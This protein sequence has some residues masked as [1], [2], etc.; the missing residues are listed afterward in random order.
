MEAYMPNTRFK[1]LAAA[2]PSLA[3]C[4]ISTSALAG[5]PAMSEAPT[6]ADYFNGADSSG[7]AALDSAEFR[8]FVDT[9]ADGG[10]AEAIG[11]RESGDYDAAFVKVDADADGIVTYLEASAH[12]EAAAPEVETD[13][14]LEEPA[15]EWVPPVAE[16]A[17]PEWEDTSEALDDVDEMSPEP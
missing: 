8:V 1:I 3:A 7:D 15:P 2:T 13:I 5:D 16:D 9:L 12:K 14:I 10:H 6:L 17:I 4:L 11:V